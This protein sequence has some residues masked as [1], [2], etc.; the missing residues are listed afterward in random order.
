MIICYGVDVTI[1]PKIVQ[2]ITLPLSYQQSY[3]CF[4]DRTTALYSQSMTN[5]LAGKPNNS[6]IEVLTGSAV[7]EHINWIT[8]GF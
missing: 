2:R 3:V 8:L 5:M 4:V 6:Q 1:G 7:S